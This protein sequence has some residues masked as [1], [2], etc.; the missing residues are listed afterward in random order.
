MN[1]QRRITVAVQ[2]GDALEFRCDV[3]ALKF[4]QSLYGVDLAVCERLEKLGQRVALPKTNEVRLL[5]TRGLLGAKAVLFVG[6]VQLNR[7]DYKQIREFG[8]RV[9]ASLTGGAPSVEHLAL[10]IHGPGY[11]LDE[12]EA[13]MS[14][15]AGIVEAIVTHDFPP[16]LERISLVERNPGRAKRL[17]EAL[18]EVLPGGIIDQSEGGRS[19]E[20]P[21]E[22]RSQALRT[23]GSTSA[24]K[25]HVFVAM[26]F[27]G[28]MEDVFHYGIQSAVKAAGFLCERADLTSFVGDVMEWVKRRIS[29]ATFVIADLTSKNP[30]VYLEVGYSWGCGRP[31]I[32]LVH[33]SSDLEFDVKGQ[34]CLV[35]GSIKQLEEL[36]GKELQSI[37]AAL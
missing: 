24:A 20:S 29:S 30:N 21:G 16:D 35:Y 34:R 17:Q 10:T 12:I 23:A 11:G 26:P 31:T 19:L 9:L 25:P 28:P 36:L 7:F 3:L 2:E 5:P 4:A 22:Q 37:V 13:M 14:E 18:N 33:D 6:V 8:R 32:L 27:A 15:L 1:A